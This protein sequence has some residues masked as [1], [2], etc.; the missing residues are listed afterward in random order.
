MP[1][2]MGISRIDLTVSRLRASGGLVP[3]RFVILAATGCA[4]R[5]TRV[6]AVLSVVV[7]TVVGA[8][9]VAVMARGVVGAL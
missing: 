6:D 1:E 4:A 9:A 8:A 5:M 7:R 2:L 3:G